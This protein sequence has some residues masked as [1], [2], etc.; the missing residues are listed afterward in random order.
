[1]NWKLIPPGGITSSLRLR[2]G[3]LLFMLVMVSM[4]AAALPLLM[5]GGRLRLPEAL[6]D[7]AANPATD[8]VAL[9][10]IILFLAGLLVV[11][12]Y[13]QVL[14]PIRRLALEGSLSGEVTG[15]EVEVL[16]GRVRHLLDTMHRTQAQLEESHETLRQT[17][18]LALVGKLAAGVAHSIRN[19]L[20]SVKL[21][22][23]SLER[24]LTLDPQQR[25]DFEVIADEIRHLDAIVSNFLEFSRR[26]KLRMQTISP[27]DVVDN[28]LQLLKHR[29][30]SFNVQV[31]LH[32]TERLPEVKGDPEQL[33]EALVNLVLNACEAMGYDG[34][35]DIIE[36]RGIITPLGRAVVIRIADSGPGVSLDRREDI[37]QPFFSTKEE[38]TGLGLPIAKSIFEEHGGWLHLHS[39]PGR[40]ATFV[41]VLPALKDD[42]W[43]RS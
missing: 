36:E 37:F 17:E 34:R 25:E 22:L 11:V 26:P 30:E 43:L 13:R 18:K 20:T 29:I 3:L 1:M 5:V 38:G 39:A 4:A 7:F 24:S 33:K 2:V 15:N 27:S 28:T 16:V 42:S 21:R 32:R 23:F 14:G 9:L 8:A 41:A 6:G 35:L 31:Q 12:V 40:G 19:P 10:C